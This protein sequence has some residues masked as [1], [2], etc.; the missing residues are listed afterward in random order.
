MSF[1][2]ILLV[3]S[4]FALVSHFSFRGFCVSIRPH[5]NHYSVVTGLSDCEDVLPI[6]IGDDKTDEDAFK[7]T[8]RQSSSS[9]NLDMDSS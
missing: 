1:C 5:L 2:L 8:K 7:V 9:P 6:Y 3:L 4:H